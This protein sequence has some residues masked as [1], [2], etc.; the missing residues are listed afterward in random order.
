[1]GRPRK[2]NLN[3]NYFKKIDSN[4]KACVLGFIY[5]DGSVN[6]NY[7]SI[8]LSKKMSKFWSL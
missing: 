1:M 2:F 4:N 3:E 8:K 5:A 7:L 6:K